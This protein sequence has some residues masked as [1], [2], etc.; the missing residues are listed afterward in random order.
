[1]L[2]AAASLAALAVAAPAARAQTIDY[3]SLEQLFGEPVTTSATGSPQKATEAPVDMEIITADDIRRSG[4]RDIPGV[5][6]HVSGVNVERWTNDST[7]ISVRG[8]DQG[9]SPRLL[10][11]IDGRQ[12]YAD[13]FGFTPWSTLPVE[14]SEIRQIEVVK[15][16]NS[17][18]FG[19]NAVGGVVNIVTYNPL[20]DDAKTV[21]LLGGTQGLAEGN[22]VGIAK[23]GDWAGLRIGV[24]GR[25][26]DDFT[27]PQLAANIGTRR[28]DNRGEINIEGVFRLADNVQA[29]IEAT[30]SQ[31]AEDAVVE[32]SNNDYQKY[33]TSSVKGQITADTNFGLITG[34]VYSNWI[35]AQTFNAAVLTPVVTVANQVTVVQLQ[36]LYKIGTDTT[37]RADLEYRHNTGTALDTPGANVFYDVLSASVMWEWKIAPE[38]TLTNALRLDDLMLGRDGTAP[39]APFTNADWN[40]TTVEPS[41]NSGV[42]W[43]PDDV[44]AFRATAARGVQVPNLVEF[45]LQNFVEP[46]VALRGV[47]DIAPTI[48]TNYEF[49][50]DHQIP[51][52]DG[53]F[54]FAAF[55]EQTDELSAINATASFGPTGLV[56]FAGN[57]G[58]STADGLELEFS[59]KFLK[60]WHW[61]LSYT[62]EIITDHFN[63][64]SPT[65]LTSADFQHT[66]PDHIVKANI[67]WAH[68]KWEIDLHSQYQSQTFG[69]VP[70]GL[71]ASLTPISDWFST[72]ARV[73]YKVTDWATLALDGQNI[74]QSTQQ[75][76][77][78]PKVERVVFGSVTFNF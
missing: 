13:Y 34:T 54:R 21:T 14:L 57:I 7:D 20:Y 78:G 9:F 11:L 46:G 1:M 68:D 27:T 41:F 39:P 72:D 22:A 3:G 48:V 31:A 76:T 53:Q 43:R 24:G 45:G 19:F 42:V 30:R 71:G 18:L 66:N 23:L 29:T 32:G 64:A 67:G 65:A 59:G 77:A 47:P 38:W 50:W 56:V 10:V 63:P 25:S 74:T 12:V 62:P 51:S 15:G 69:L 28:G 6:A 55:H 70:N 2:F 36:D 52:L 61:D 44:N 5:L 16:P 35:D 75:Q 73:A 40:R 8:Y 33:L 26:D 58:S 60:D 17:A 4:A 49:G 37:L